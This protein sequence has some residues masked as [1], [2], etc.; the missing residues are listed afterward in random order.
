MLKF[1]FLLKILIELKFSSSTKYPNRK[2]LVWKPR[3]MDPID[4][5]FQNLHLGLKQSR[6]GTLPCNLS[7]EGTIIWQQ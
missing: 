6:P 3:T 2:L 1:I 5:V 7:P 4:I